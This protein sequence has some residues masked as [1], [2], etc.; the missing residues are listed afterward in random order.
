VRI[1]VIIDVGDDLH[2]TAEVFTHHV[3]DGIKVE[4][5]DVPKVLRKLADEITDATG[6]QQAIYAND[7]D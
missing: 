5:E 6:R 7:G 4:G 3:V 2:S 1:C